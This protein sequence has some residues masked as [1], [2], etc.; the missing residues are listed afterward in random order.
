MKKFLLM[1]VALFTAS[2]TMAYSVKG[3]VVNQAGEPLEFATYR[4][5]S[6]TDTVKPVAYGVTDG[7]GV[8]D[9]SLNAAGT[10]TARASSVG[11]ADA[12]VTFA[13]SDDATAA[14]LGKLVC[15]DVANML[16]E[17][18]VTATKPLV[19]KEID[20]LG[21]DV[22][23]D[24]EAPT[25][26]L[27]DILRKVPLVSVDPDGTIKVRGSSDFKIYKNGRPDNSFTRNAKEIFKAI[28]ASMVRKI[29]VITDPGA[30]EDAEGVGA[31][32]NI[33]TEQGS[34]LKGIMANVG[35]N[36]ST[37]DQI[38]SPNLWGSAQI[39][40]VTL[41][42]YA[43]LNSI[44]RLNNERVEE[45][46]GI[47]RDSGRESRSLGHGYAKGLVSWW[48]IDASYELDSL[49]LFT[50]EFGGTAVL[51]VCAVYR[52]DLKNAALIDIK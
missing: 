52:F 30:R 4:I 2:V 13:V 37:L 42:A 9:R 45:R 15:G 32:L 28:P 46:Q 1:T 40:K 7:T 24:V 19:T 18:T 47:Y 34:S 5:Y 16:G 12:V 35:L 10:Y 27:Q 49:N 39:D 26:N 31:I 38:P 25:S 20:R 41:S 44:S 3:V 11:L 51:N 50:I 43:G 14:D 22:K 48:G 8:F 36:Y 33:V 23:A 17:V 6:A 21:Y 29:E